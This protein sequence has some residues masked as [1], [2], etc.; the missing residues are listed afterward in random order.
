MTRPHQP[1]DHPYLTCMDGAR[2]DVPD[3]AHTPPKQ[4]REVDALEVQE[5]HGGDRT[6]LVVRGIDAGTGRS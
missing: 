6:V 5:P 1:D 4:L 3:D 2:R